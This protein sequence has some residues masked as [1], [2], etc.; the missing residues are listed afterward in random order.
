MC[1]VQSKWFFDEKQRMDFQCDT[2]AEM[3]W[4]REGWSGEHH[5]GKRSPMT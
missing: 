2:G 5:R 3:Q 1:Y 4:V